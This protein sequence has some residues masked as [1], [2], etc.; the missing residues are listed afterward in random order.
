MVGRNIGNMVA[1]SSPHPKLICHGRK[2]K[3][4]HITSNESIETTCH[5]LKENPTFV[6]RNHAHPPGPGSYPVSGTASRFTPGHGSLGMS[7]SSTCKEKFSGSWCDVRGG[8]FG[9]FNV[10]VSTWFS[11]LPPP[12]PKFNSSP[13]KTDHPNRKGLSSNHHFSGASC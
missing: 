5:F 6:A 4:Q 1:K 10:S 13:L 7:C 2:S 9:S 3:N 11:D 8:A 12:P